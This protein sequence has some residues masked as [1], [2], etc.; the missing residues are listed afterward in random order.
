[1]FI[2]KLSNMLGAGELMFFSSD[3]DELEI[4]FGFLAG[5]RAFFD[6]GQLM[7]PVSLK[8]AGPFMKR[9]NCIE[10]GSIEH[11]AP[12]PPHIHKAHINHNAD[13]LVTGRL[14]HIKDCTTPVYR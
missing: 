7:P 11:L 8:R 6:A 12:L 13:G 2:V 1:M 10:V 5:L 9:A 3:C 14:S 4:L